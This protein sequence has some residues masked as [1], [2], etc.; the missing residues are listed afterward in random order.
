MKNAKNIAL[1]L[2][3]SLAILPLGACAGMKDKK[4]EDDTGKEP[5]TSSLLPF[6]IVFDTKGNPFVQDKKGRLITPEQVKFPIKDVKEIEN[7]HAISVMGVIGS[8]YYIVIIG[9][10]AYKIMLPH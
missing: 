5:S 10:N 8:H 7:L 3:L 4:D 9:G 1:S 6:S 2:A